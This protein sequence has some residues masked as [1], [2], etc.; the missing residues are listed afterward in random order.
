MK[1]QI[2]EDNGGNIYMNTEQLKSVSS[3]MGFVVGDALGVPVEFRTRGVLMKSPVTDMREG[4]SHHQPAG[5]WSDDSSMVVATM[6]WIGELTEFPEKKD[7]N[8]LMKK[9]GRWLKRGEYTPYGEVFDCDYCISSAIERYAKGVAPLKCG[10]KMEND[11]GNGSLLRVLPVALGFN[12]TLSINENEVINMIFEISQLTHAHL[13]SKIACYIYSKII[14]DIMNSE[15]KDKFEIVEK[16]INCCREFLENKENTEINEEI[17]RFGRLWNMETFVNLD[18]DYIKSGSY[19]VHTLEAALWCFLNTQ[20]YE[21]C[22]LKAVNLGKD[23]DAIG[24]MAGGLAGLYY[25]Y[26][27]IPQIWLETIPK[28]EWIEELAKEM[29]KEWGEENKNNLKEFL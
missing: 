25:G 2:Y 10:G 18:E 21:E 16:S 17:K 7:Y 8:I 20:D 27:N 6:E 23:T 5:T 3:I 12:K 28:R 4:G 29:M 14:A 9:F 22:V 26:E 24:A 1:R 13:R 11:N 15:M 19:V